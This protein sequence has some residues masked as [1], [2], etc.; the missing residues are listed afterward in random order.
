MDIETINLNNNQIPI[1]ITC[2]TYIKDIDG[3]SLFLI[4]KDLLIKD[5]NKAVTNL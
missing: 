1:A 4:D 2:S 5:S 3:N